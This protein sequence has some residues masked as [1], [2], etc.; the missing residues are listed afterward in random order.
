MWLLQTQQATW[1]NDFKAM[2]AILFLHVWSLARAN[3][4]HNGI[5]KYHQFIDDTANIKGNDYVVHSGVKG[6]VIVPQFA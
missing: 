4:K 6:T 1:L 3:Y 2:C 5:C